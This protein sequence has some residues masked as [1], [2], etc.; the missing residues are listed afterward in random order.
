M[1]K[2]KGIYFDL[3][4]V[5]VDN[6]WPG[7]M[8]YYIKQINVKEEEFLLAV[9]KAIIDWQ[10]GKISENFFW[11]KICNEL[12]VA[13]P[14]TQSLWINGVKS[15]F[16]EKNGMFKLL[17][18]LK[19]RGYKIGL[20]SNTEKPV[21]EFLINEKKYKYFDKTVFS[22]EVGMIKPDREIYDHALQLLGLKPEETIF[23]DDKEENI[24]GA[25]KVGM[26]GILF[27]TEQQLVDQLNH[28]LSF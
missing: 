23:I 21:V 13:T 16:K 11:E 18:I 15:S 2:I 8:A 24:E 26:I 12:K 22:C 4:G 19:K 1:T 20:L 17:D 7:M 10:K 27:K 25:K 6:P 5:L 3:G 14:T 9:D 28:Y